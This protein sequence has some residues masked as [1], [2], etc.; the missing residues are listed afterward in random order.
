MKQEIINRA[1]HDA[2]F[3]QALLDDPKEAVANFLG[4]TLPPAMQITVLEEQPGHHIMVLPPAPPRLDA[5][6]L[7]ELELALVGGG[8]TLRPIHSPCNLQ[9]VRPG[10]S[11][12]GSSC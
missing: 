9:Y 1:S 11:V 12:Y 7:K 5:L 6:P 10:R 8:R 4:M 3:R 2:D